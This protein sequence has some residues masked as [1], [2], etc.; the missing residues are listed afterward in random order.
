MLRFHSTKSFTSRLSEMPTEQGGALNTPSPSARA[1]V[2]PTFSGTSLPYVWR[3][4]AVYAAVS[5]YT[6]PLLEYANPLPMMR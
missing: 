5:K 4:L 6:E 3:L 2:L 1:S